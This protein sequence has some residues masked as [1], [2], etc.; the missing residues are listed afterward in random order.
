V[1]RPNQPDLFFT[2]DDLAAEL[3]D[4]FEIVTNVAAPREVTDHE[5]RLVT[6]HDTVFRARRV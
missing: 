3:A 4:G 1:P 6:I 5:G 2:G